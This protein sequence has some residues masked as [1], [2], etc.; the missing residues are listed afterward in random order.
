MFCGLI[1]PW[2]DTAIR[3]DMHGPPDFLCAVHVYVPFPVVNEITRKKKAPRMFYSRDRN[4][5]HSQLVKFCTQLTREI[6][7]HADSCVSIM[8]KEVLLC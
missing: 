5:S 8:M 6:V 4:A 1:I 2:T 7:R 3:A